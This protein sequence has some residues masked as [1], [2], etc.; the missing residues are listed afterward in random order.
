MKDNHDL[1]AYFTRRVQAIVAKHG[2]KMIGWDEILHPTF[3]TTSWCNPGTGRR[4]WRTPPAW[5]S[6]EFSPRGITSTC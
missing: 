6:A 5:V 4:R 2:K 1:Q 3:P